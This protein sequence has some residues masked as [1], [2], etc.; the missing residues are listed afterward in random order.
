MD[1]EDA[2]RR[3]QWSEQK[4]MRIVAEFERICGRQPE[5]VSRQKGRSFDMFSYGPPDP[6]TGQ[7][8]VRRIEVKGRQINEPVTISREEWNT[9]VSHPNSYWLYVVINPTGSS[10]ELLIIRDPA[11]KLSSYARTEPNGDKTVTISAVRKVCDE[12]IRDI[13]SFLEANKVADRRL[14][15]DF[16]PIG[17]V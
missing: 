5:D 10:P 6:A 12:R 15:E 8:E 2:L 7:R 16:L 9:A 1:S 17:V 13:L 4:A 3:R 14:I 11:S